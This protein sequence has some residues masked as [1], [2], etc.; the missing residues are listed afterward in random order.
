MLALSIRQ[1]YAEQILLGKK[2]ME[3]RSDCD[4]CSRKGLHLRNQT[5]AS[6][7]A[8]ETAWSSCRHRRDR[9]TVAV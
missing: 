5:L 1:P 2:K 6:D 8:E 9:E 3:Y 7:A 4:D